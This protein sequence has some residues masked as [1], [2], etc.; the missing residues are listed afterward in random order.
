MTYCQALDAFFSLCKWLT[1]IKPNKRHQV[2]AIFTQEEIS[3]GGPMK[4]QASDTYQAYKHRGKQITDLSQSFLHLWTLV[5]C[6]FFFFLYLPSHFP[7]PLCAILV[8]FLHC[9]HFSFFFFFAALAHSD[10]F[11]ASRVMQVWLSVSVD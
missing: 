10:A 7:P 9:F 8:L 4:T 5:F 2:S 11:N 3:M 1:A 6:F